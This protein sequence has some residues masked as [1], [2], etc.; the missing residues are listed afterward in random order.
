MIK[1]I[2][3][4]K[5]Y[6]WIEFV[7]WLQSKY[8]SYYYIEDA[9]INKTDDAE[10]Y[11]NDNIKK[12]IDDLNKTIA[13]VVEYDTDWLYVYEMRYDNGLKRFICTNQYK[14]HIT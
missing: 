11:V 1:P 3:L 13:F 8:S 6:N 2:Q 5:F 9:F 12:Y 4:K 14:V 7:D 10:R